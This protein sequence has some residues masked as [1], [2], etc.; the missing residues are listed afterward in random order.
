MPAPT[1]T[2]MLAAADGTVVSISNDSRSYR[3]IE[4]ILRH[5]PEETG[6]PVW[7]Y[8]QYAH[9]DTAPKVN[10]GDRVK[11]GQDLGPTG[12]SGFSNGRKVRRPAIH[13]AAWYSDKP[14]FFTNG[15]GIA[16]VDGWWMVTVAVRLLLATLRTARMTMAAAL[17]SRPLVGSSMNS[18]SGRRASA[19]ASAR[20]CCSPPDRRRAG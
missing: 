14:G 4:V 19:R 1:G 5:T 3:G 20:R 6:L 12:N 2:P 11:L 9:L 17:A 8:T 16:P 10:V 7:T 15:R 18:T 13:F